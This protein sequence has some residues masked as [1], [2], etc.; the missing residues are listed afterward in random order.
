MSDQK[1]YETIEAYLN[2]DLNGKDLSEFEAQIKSD[3]K[4][5]DQI[6]IFKDIDYV[7]K[8][9]P[10]LDFQKLVANEGKSFLQEKDKTKTIVK[11]FNWRRTI[12]AAATLIIIASALFVWKS[13]LNTPSTSKE[14]FAQ[15][16]E[17]YELNESLRGTTNN[18]KTFDLAMQSYQNRD[19]NSA[20]ETFKNLS[21]AKPTDIVITF[22]LANAYLNQS[23]KRFAAA[24]VEFEKIIVEDN[25]IY[26]P[27]SKWYLSLILLEQDKRSDA[28]KLLMEIKDIGD[29]LGT[30]TNQL[31]DQLND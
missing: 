8:D 11:N 9:K 15:H 16:F 12:I 7:I 26:V 2:G 24:K 20:V 4:L 29:N 18:T 6:A 13:Q 14:L 27:I 19:F 10:I 1:L 3:K 17:S 22:C 23:P 30:K 5:A 31:I 21:I 28:K 25:S